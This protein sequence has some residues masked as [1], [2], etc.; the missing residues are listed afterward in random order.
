LVVIG[1]HF[2]ARTV[3]NCRC[4]NALVVSGNQHV[5]RSTCDRA[6]EDA[7]DHRQPPYVGKR[8]ARQSHGCIA[9][10]NHDSKSRHHHLLSLTDFSNDRID[11]SFAVA[12]LKLHIDPHDPHLGLSSRRQF[13]GILFRDEDWQFVAEPN[14]GGCERS[15]VFMRMRNYAQAGFFE[16]TEKSLGMAD[17]GNSMNLPPRKIGQRTDGTVGETHGAIRAYLRLQSTGTRPTGSVDDDGVDAIQPCGRLAQWT[18]GQAEPISK[19]AL[20]IDNHYL[21]ISRQ[22]MVLQAVIRYDDI[23][24]GLRRDVRDSRSPVSPDDDGA[25]RAARQQQRL[26]ADA[27]DVVADENLNDGSLRLCAV[28][29]RHDSRRKTPIAQLLDQI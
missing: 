1:R 19:T 27:L 9:G 14:V 28:T 6:P 26:I 16:Q 3:S 18:G 4:G 2:D 17:T 24:T 7:Y 22:C 20:T 13:Y 8:L 5:R 29:S 21:E 25:A 10:R 23:G 12:W 15:M 11:E